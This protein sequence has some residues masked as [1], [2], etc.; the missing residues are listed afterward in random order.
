MNTYV[1][2]EVSLKSFHRYRIKVFKI[3]L[4]YVLSYKQLQRAFDIDPRILSYL[5]H[6]RLLNNNV[7][8][9]EFVTNAKNVLDSYVVDGIELNQVMVASLNLINAKH[10]NIIET[11]DIL[12]DLTIIDYEKEVRKLH[13]D[14]LGRY[15][16][17]LDNSK[18][19][20]SEYKNN[21]HENYIKNVDPILNTQYYNV[22]RFLRNE[23]KTRLNILN[24]ILDID[25][26]STII[27]NGNDLIKDAFSKRYEKI[28]TYVENELRKILYNDAY[29]R[30]LRD[31][32]DSINTMLDSGYSPVLEEMLFLT[33]ANAVADIKRQYT[34]NML[35]YNELDSMK[36]YFAVR[37][38][39]EKTLVYINSYTVSIGGCYDA[40]QSALKKHSDMK[41][42]YGKLAYNAKIE[43]ND[44]I[45]DS[46]IEDI[47]SIDVARSFTNIDV[48]TGLDNITK[49][50]LS[51]IRKSD[52][53]GSLE[54]IEIGSDS[55]IVRLDDMLNQK[56]KSPFDIIKNTVDS[57]EKNGVGSDEKMALMVKTFSK[58]TLNVNSHMKTT[59]SIIRDNV[60]STK[61]RI[62][63]SIRNRRDFL[64]SRYSK[65]VQDIINEIEA[66]YIRNKE[67][68]DNIYKINL[69]DYIRILALIDTSLGYS[70]GKHDIIATVVSKFEQ[71]LNELRRI[72]IPLMRRSIRSVSDEIANAGYKMGVV[73][74]DVQLNYDSL[75]S[76]VGNDA[77]DLLFDVT[78]NVKKFK[79][80]IENYNS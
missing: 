22:V 77:Y 25:P 5:I 13:A 40:R 41:I 11:L 30:I 71:G 6:S 76:R 16:S 80:D 65:N 66:Q 52:D 48:V 59:S 72:L 78:N 8:V 70:M 32:K 14:M 44:Q 20:L 12:N 35:I 73:A 39:K 33:T 69:N 34:S 43:K 64:I 56:V 2:L 36:A 17:M 27:R 50:I 37:P 38:F 68:L 63:A 21:I 55:W 23:V 26:F 74:K 18:N 42:E 1:N 24:D 79:D 9:N 67:A 4:T 7:I 58:Y 15:R 28:T 10:I 54:S 46:L 45:I 49:P 61:L 53:N 75:M 62:R 51:Q 19:N 31:C 3:P 29:A 57:I 47:E 60:E